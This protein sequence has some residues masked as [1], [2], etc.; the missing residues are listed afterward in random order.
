[1]A[2]SV[3][4]SS[5]KVS[6][7]S[8]AVEVR[9]LLPKHNKVKREENAPKP[10]E[11]TLIHTNIHRL[12][13]II[14]LKVILFL[15]GF[16]PNLVFF[17]FSYLVTGLRNYMLRNLIKTIRESLK[18]SAAVRLKMFDVNSFLELKCLII[19]NLASY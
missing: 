13:V 2:I 5:V 18:K 11:N 7:V 17:L 3:R 8:E 6:F 19:K 15:Q 9:E 16:E 1:M 4:T 14:M 10:H 12:Q